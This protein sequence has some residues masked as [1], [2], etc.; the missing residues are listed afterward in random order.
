MLS[1]HFVLLP[2]LSL[3]TDYTYNKT[4]Q[5]YM[6]MSAF[7]I[8]DM[9]IEKKQ[10]V[11]FRYENQDRWVEPYHY[12]KLGNDQ[13]LHGYQIAGG[14]NS[15]AIPAWRNF[16]LEK[17]QL[18]VCNDKEFNPRES[19]NPSNAKYQT[20]IKQIDIEANRNSIKFRK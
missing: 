12:G 10:L 5:E 4:I 6:F 9:A 2:S 13:Q 15:K 16:K 8:L 1:Q 19:Y 14:S 3:N 7:K 11:H 18:L 20:I 17:I